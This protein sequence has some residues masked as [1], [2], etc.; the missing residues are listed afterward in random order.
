MEGGEYKSDVDVN[1]D[2]DRGT[3]VIDDQG[4]DGRSYRR[5][6]DVDSDVD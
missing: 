4:V 5:S 6:C 2:V 1:S 3:K